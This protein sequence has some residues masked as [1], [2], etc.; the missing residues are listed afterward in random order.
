M[1]KILDLLTI[2]GMV[3]ASLS[4]YAKKSESNC[5]E[6]LS[7]VCPMN[8][9]PVT[10]KYQGE[11]KLNTKEWKGTNH[12]DVTRKIDYFVCLHL[13]SADKADFAAQIKCEKPP[14]K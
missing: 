10:C 14:E 11:Q 3:S 12:C 7:R 1:K 8:Y 9:D 13:D 5:S 6:I 4:A 2:L